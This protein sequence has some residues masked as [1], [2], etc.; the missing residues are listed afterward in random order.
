MSLELF[1]RRVEALSGEHSLEIILLLRERGWSIALDIA[2]ALHIH[3][4]TVMKYLSKMR[5]AGIVAKRAKKCRTGSTFEYKLSSQKIAVSLD[6]GSE[7]IHSEKN[8]TPALDLI[9]RIADKLEEIGNPLNPE[10]FKSEREKELATLI[11]SGK[12]QKV[13]SLAKEDSA[14]LFKVLK[15]LIEFSEKSLGKTVTK[16]IILSASRSLPSS[17]VDFVPDYV[18]EVLT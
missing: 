12:E 1:K 3:P 8:V 13:A 9:S 11:V 4:T 14:S 15:G 18:Q 16:D 7:E 5:Q 6:L 17:I 2:K 10:I